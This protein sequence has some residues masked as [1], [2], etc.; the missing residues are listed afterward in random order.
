MGVSSSEL[1]AAAALAP[2][3]FDVPETVAS[4]MTAVPSTLPMTPRMPMIEGAARTLSSASAPPHVGTP[5]VAMSTLA[6][7]GSGAP[8]PY[9]TPPPRADVGADT[10]LAFNEPSARTA[11]DLSAA[12]LPRRTGRVVPVVA[13][14]VVVLVAVAGVALGLRA[15]KT[16]GVATP[17]PA[18]TSSL[19]AAASATTPAASTAT[20]ATPAPALSPTSALVPTVAPAGSARRTVRGST[21][22]TTPAASTTAAA[23]PAATTKKPPPNPYANE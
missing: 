9:V 1:P 23:Q 12:G 7:G 14:L 13:G 10:Q 19:S 3:T 4:P 18:D 8:G 2:P 17:V 6:S 20:S 15:A 21:P 11:H 5:G 16:K 22:A